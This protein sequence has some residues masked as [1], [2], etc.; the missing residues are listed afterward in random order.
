MTS[1]PRSSL[2][3]EEILRFLEYTPPFSELDGE[4]LGELADTCREEH[5]P[6]G[7]LVLEKGKSRV[8]SL[9]I[10][11]EGRMRLFLRDDEGEIS[12]EDFRGPGEVVGALGI[13]RDSLSN[14]EVVTDQDTICV[15]I[16]RQDFLEL[17]QSNLAFA[18]YYL[19]TI[20]ESYVSKA[21]TQLE[22]PRPQVGGEGTLYLFSAQVGDV[23]RRRPEFIGLE[24][25]AQ[26]AARVMDE[27]RV[28]CLLVEEEG[29]GLHGIVTDR[30]LRTKVVARGMDGET[31]VREIMTAPV[32]AIPAHTLCF[33]ALLEMMRRGVHHL[34]LTREGKTVGVLS[35]HDLMITTGSS[36]LA[37]VRE[38]GGVKRIEELYDISLK[39]PR[40]VA[41]LIYEGAKASN[42][43]RMITLINDYILD[44]LLTLLVEELGQPPAPFCWMLMGSEG[45]REQTFR[46]DQDNGLIYADPD[47]EEHA[48]A[49]RNYFRYLGTMAIE[50][51]VACGFPRCEGG[52]MASNPKWCQP[53]SAWRRQ[54]DQWVTTPDPQ[55]I[56]YTTIFFDFRGGYGHLELTESLRGH[57]MQKVRGKEVFLR[58]LAK[59]TLT[60]PSALSF[61]RNFAVEKDGAHAGKLDLKHKGLVPFIDYARVMSLAH[62][63]RE[64]NTLERM[65]MLFENDVISR[66]FYLS[67]S[68]AFEFQMRLR[69]VHQQMQH[70]EGLEP[71]NYI[72]PDDL[73]DMERRNLKEALGV[74]GEI[75]G[76]LKSEYRLDMG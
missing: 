57:L 19:K 74:V 66:D 67:L 6:A 58:H 65:L 70:E 35:G 12:L 60:T 13:L 32:H 26:H 2:S 21:L 5:L 31:P 63:V 18:R 50:H 8:D 55:E 71:D 49:C 48:E 10:I 33:D 52:I 72:D 62:G 76:R 14:L 46:T 1:P 20:T 30:D 75:K 61:F 4:V 23:V 38:I 59:D 41:S 22:R 25:T 54:F 51:L 73:S 17:I 9:R 3:R 27:R 39:S 28:G 69:L 24:D 43:T 56:L 45:R 47:D 40:V 37:L 11:Y 15:L 36:P 16:S 53:Y 34:P 64:T 29:G 44:R 7:T 68:Q 42:I